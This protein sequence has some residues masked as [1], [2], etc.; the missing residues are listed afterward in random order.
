MENKYIWKWMLA[1]FLSLLALMLL[2]VAFRSEALA[3]VSVYDSCKWFLTC[4]S[5]SRTE[6]TLHDEIKWT[7]KPLEA[8]KK[9]EPVKVP[10]K[11][12]KKQEPIKE[13]TINNSYDLD[14]LAKAVA[15]AETGNCTKGYWKTYNN[16]FWIKN[17]NTAPCPKIGKSK[18][19]IYEKPE[20]SYEAFKK[21]WEKWYKWKPNLKTAQRWTGHDNAVRWLSHVNLHYNKWT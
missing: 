18:M 6:I 16:C 2:V 15:I 9:K 10:P 7:P 14:R 17:W 8:P 5:E 12:E 21:I 20:D 1:L 13:V 3:W 4:G 11:V 19:C